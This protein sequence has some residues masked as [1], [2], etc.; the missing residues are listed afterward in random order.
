MK[1]GNLASEYTALPCYQVTTV[2]LTHACTVMESLPQYHINS[3]SSE[4]V[5]S[6]VSV[7]P[8]ATSGSQ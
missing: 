5:M 4:Y 2:A 7:M 6:L 1:P 3:K 8:L